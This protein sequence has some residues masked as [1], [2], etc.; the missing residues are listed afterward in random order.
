MAAI[1]SRPSGDTGRLFRIRRGWSTN[2]DEIHADDSVLR[3]RCFYP[4]AWLSEGDVMLAKKVALE[5]F[6][7]EALSVANEWWQE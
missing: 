2:I 3:T 4:V 6:E 7:R 1:R 5:V